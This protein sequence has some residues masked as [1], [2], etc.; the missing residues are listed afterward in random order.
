MGLQV[1]HLPVEV[2]AGLQ[3]PH[4]ALW[5]SAERCDMSRS[6][7]KAGRRRIHAATC[8]HQLH[9]TLQLW[10]TRHVINQS[11]RERSTMQIKI[12]ILK[13]KKKTV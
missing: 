6:L 13:K 8:L 3:E 10:E 9:H 11:W 5:V 4:Q 2:S 1:T 7:R 12:I